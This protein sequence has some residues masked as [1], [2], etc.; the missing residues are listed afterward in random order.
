MV[1]YVGKSNLKIPSVVIMIISRVFT[2]GVST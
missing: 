2:E 1:S